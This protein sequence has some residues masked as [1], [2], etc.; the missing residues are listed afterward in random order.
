MRSQKDM[1]LI[2]I[3]TTANREWQLIYN[4]STLKKLY[5]DIF[6]KITT[7]WNLPMK[8]L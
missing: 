7:Y 4:K 1:R 3:V 8:Y 6:L 2:I 5:P